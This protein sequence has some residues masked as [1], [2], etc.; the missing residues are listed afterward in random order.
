[1]K[2]PRPPPGWVRRFRSL[3]LCLC[4]AAPMHLLAGELVVSEVKP[5]DTDPAISRFNENNMVVFDGEAAP[6]QLVIFLPGTT[7]M[8]HNALRFLRVVAAQGYRVIGLE[9]NDIPAVLQLCSRNQPPGCSEAVRAKRVFGEDTTRLVDNTPAE[10]IVNRLVK[11]LRYLDQHDPAQNWGS[12]LNGGEPDWSRIVVSGLSQG[13]GM[14]A[15][16]AKHRR[17]ARVVLFSSPWDDYGASRTLAPWI[18]QPSETPAERWFA[19]YHRRENTA[20]L[21]A[22][23][24]ALLRIPADHIRVFDLDLAPGMKFRGENPYHGSTIHN[25]GYQDDWKFLFGSPGE[26]DR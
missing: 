11:L 16:I 13:A 10:S 9:Y 25:P 18:S 24:Y 7:G 1:M 20:A 5:S 14:A 6:R 17:V 3:L 8:P 26:P 4:A 15:Y 22:R 12:Y 2:C 21:I 23:A 19:E